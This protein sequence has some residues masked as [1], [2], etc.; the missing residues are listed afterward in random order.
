MGGMRGKNAF[1]CGGCDYVGGMRGK[2]AF[3]FGGC[4]YVGGIRGKNA[5]EFGGCGCMGG[6]R[7]KNAFRSQI[8][9]LVQERKRVSRRCETA[10]VHPFFVVNEA[11]TT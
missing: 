8:L 9:A 7:G 6:M 10:A 2:N 1:E 11:G 5:F 3:E 4:G